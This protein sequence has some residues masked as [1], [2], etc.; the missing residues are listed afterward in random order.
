MSDG[1]QSL[2]AF[3]LFSQ[4]RFVQKFGRKITPPSNKFF[5]KW[6]ENFKSTGTVK[7]NIWSGGNI[8]PFFSYKY[9]NDDS[10]LNLLQSEF[11]P[12]FLILP[13]SKKF[14]FMQ[15]GAPPHWSRTV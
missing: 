3:F 8:G 9:V 10:F 15:D 7:K 14:I 11:W 4:S 5:K 12:A 1:I 6:H 13:D 2:K